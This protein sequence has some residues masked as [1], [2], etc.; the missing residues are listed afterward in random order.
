VLRLADTGVVLQFD[1]FG[2]EAS[3]FTPTE[4]PFDLS[5]KAARWTWMRALI[6]TGHSF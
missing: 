6:N 4:K 2:Q 1:M 3:H 5:S